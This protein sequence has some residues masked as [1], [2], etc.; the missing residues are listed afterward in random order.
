MSDLSKIALLKQTLENAENNI[1][2]AKQILN[3]INCGK[4]KKLS[5]ELKEEVKNLQANPDGKVI[6]GIFD[7]ENMIGPDGQIYPVQPNYASKS[8]LVPGDKL[9]LTVSEDGS[10]LFKQIELIPRKRLIG[11]LIGEENDHKV[12]AEGKNYNVLLAS[13]T[14]FKGQP[15]DKVTLVVPQ[16]GKSDWGAIEN[17]IVKPNSKKEEN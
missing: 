4:N 5:K 11:T 7:G 2:S 10:F 1:I 8:K 6:E 3:E 9:K 14:Y 13:V 17:I 12:T 16:K 15:N